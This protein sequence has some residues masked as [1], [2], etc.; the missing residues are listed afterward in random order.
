MSSFTYFI[1][2]HS[3]NKMFQ[4]KVII[5]NRRP[6]LYLCTRLRFF[7]CLVNKFPPIVAN[8]VKY[9][10]PIINY[11]EISSFARTIIFSKLCQGFIFGMSIIDTITNSYTDLP[12]PR[13]IFLSKIG[14]RFHPTTMNHH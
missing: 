2:S 5:T 7:G 14:Y 6:L 4:P 11:L 1:H 9:V 12:R 13:S 3:I 8:D 10:S